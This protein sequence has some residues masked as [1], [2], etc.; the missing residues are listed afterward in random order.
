MPFS[1][2]FFL[3]TISLIFYSSWVSSGRCKHQLSIYLFVLAFCIVRRSTLSSLFRG[4]IFCFKYFS[5]LNICVCNQT[6]IFGHFWQISSVPFCRLSSSCLGNPYIRKLRAY[7]LT[8]FFCDCN[9]CK[10]S[11]NS[12]YHLTCNARNDSILWGIVFSP[13]IQPNSQ[14]EKP[15]KIRGFWVSEY[16]KRAG[17]T[18]KL[19]KITPIIVIIGAKF[20]CFFK[21]NPK[22]FYISLFTHF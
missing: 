13:P 18:P 20:L 6:E 17:S 15:H 21:S 8:L 1:S 22:K 19:Q 9:N 12:I 4:T 10:N 3:A 2:P 16:Q 7:N 5:C 11:L 14:D